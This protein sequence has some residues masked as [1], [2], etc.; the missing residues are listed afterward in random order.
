MA[1]IK[2]IK[3]KNI[4]SP[5]GLQNAVVLI[6][7][8]KIKDV[9]AEQDIGSDVRCEDIGDSILMP[10]LIDCHVHI[11]EPG[12]TDWEGFETATKAAA[13]GGITS[14]IEMPLNASPVTTN[15]KNFEIKLAATHNKLSVHCG[16]W[17]GVVPDNLDELEGLLQSGVFGL[18]AFLTH[19]GIDD[20]PNTTADQLRKALSILKK[21]NKPLLVHCELD[22]PHAE[23]ILLENNPTSYAAYLKSRPK[24]WENKA[25][26]LMIDLCRES[27]ARV[28]LVHISSA[29]ALPLIAAA[30]AEGLPLTA[31]T[32]PHYLFFHSEIIPDGNTSFKCAP[33]IREKSNNDQLWEALKS[34]TLD[35]VVSD[36]SP[37]PPELKEM[38]SGN[39]KKAWGG[40]AGLQFSLPV[41]WTAA[42]EKGFSI[43]DISRLLTV[44]VANFI[45]IGAFKGKIE[46]GYDAD[47]VVWN[48]ESKFKVEPALI[49]H[50]HKLTPYSELELYGH[51]EQTYV[52]G[53]LVYDNGKFLHLNQ[54]NVLLFPS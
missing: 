9:L 26:Q 41:M 12:R 7:G 6:E 42:K 52:S 43:Q 47:I 2:F 50:K 4:L 32:C 44:H 39:F 34:G 27:G 20:F 19:S 25:V 40:I 1:D 21:Y 14:L 11:N 51:V 38:R 30:K 31:E 18:K 24:S 37:A 35:F 13:A 3:G 15:A 45:G 16:F 17:G 53:K 54:G 49:Q 5:S 46:K 22:S 10:G 33:P 28:H 48:P 23:Q 29:E 36:H 8:S